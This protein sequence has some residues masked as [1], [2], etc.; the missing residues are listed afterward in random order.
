MMVWFMLS[1]IAKYPTLKEM[2]FN[3]NNH[4]YTGLYALLE[5]F[6]NHYN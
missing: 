3:F 1:R 4:M 5:S 2:K 6:I